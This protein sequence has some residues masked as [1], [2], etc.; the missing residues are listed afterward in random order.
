MKFKDVCTDIL[1]I[2]IGALILAFGIN[3]FL[4]PNEIAAGGV[5]GIATVL[6]ITFKIPMSVTVI[7]VNGILFAF[8]FK[9]LKVYELIKSILGII[10]LSFFLE[11]TQ[12][13][14]IYKEDILISAIFGG[15]F[16]GI[17]IGITVSRGASTGG[18]DMMA[19]MV[20]RSLRGVSV[21]LIILITDAIVILISGFAFSSITIM[22]YAVIAVYI[23]S[24]ATD[25][26]C[27]FGD[28]EKQVQIISEKAEVISER[29]MRELQRGTT[30]FYTRGMYTG[31]SG[32]AIICI[33]RRNEVSKVIKIINQT[34]K[35][36]F[37]TICDVR[38]VI[39]EG[40]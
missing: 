2:F 11:V 15:V 30:G 17:G 3:I 32:M 16:C 20:A 9:K 37:V 35:K 33:V 23:T 10:F 34:D 14:Y 18:S 38:E 12:N 25:F 24:V 7:I 27:N 5:S 28:A 6:F 22:L 13:I 40:F 36:A 8:G 1:C 4:L 39:G 31:N 29:I 26:V 19:L 21:A